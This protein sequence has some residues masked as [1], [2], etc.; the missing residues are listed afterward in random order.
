MPCAAPVTRATLWATLM[1]EAVRDTGWADDDHRPLVTG[2][3][4]QQT[5]GKKNTINDIQIV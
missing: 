4:K 3:Q 1:A 2:G 5:L